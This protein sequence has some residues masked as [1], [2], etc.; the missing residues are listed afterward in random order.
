MYDKISAES[1]YKFIHEGLVTVENRDSVDLF[2]PWS[3][4]DEPAVGE[5]LKITIRRVREMHTSA[6]PIKQKYSTASV[7]DAKY[8]TYEITDNGRAIAELERRVGDLAPYRDRIER[9]LYKTGMFT[10]RS[11]RII[12]RTYSLY[13]DW[14]HLHELGKIL[15]LISLISRL[16]MMPH[17]TTDEFSRDSVDPTPCNVPSQKNKPI[18]SKEVVLGI[19]SAISSLYSTRATDNEI[20][21]NCSVVFDGE[22]IPLSFR[23]GEGKESVIESARGFS[24]WMGRII[25]NVDKYRPYIVGVCRALGVSYDFEKESLSLSYRRNDMRVSEA[26]ARMHQAMLLV[27]AMD[28]YLFV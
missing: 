15:M 7:D 6:G 27:G 25:Y 19:S 26:V 5:P 22:G 3:F 9:L 2:L 17:F 1:L 23:L 18:E 16:Y 11:D 4:G 20:L 10:L 14:L 13:A 12:T 24:D 21:I 28:W 8:D